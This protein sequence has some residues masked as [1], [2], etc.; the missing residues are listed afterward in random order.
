MTY[1][2]ATLPV[3]A[4]AYDEIAAKLR[5]ADYGHVFSGSGETEHIDMTHIALSRGED[6]TY[7]RFDATL[8]VDATMPIKPTRDTSHS[9]GGILRRVRAWLD[10]Y[11]DPGATEKFLL[12][13]GET[14]E[15]RIYRK[16][17]VPPG[18]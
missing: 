5:A 4:A 17:K 8:P 2:V 3:S 1:T 6:D 14:F 7:L 15:V 12:L 18:E 11:L 9:K 10:A 16:G 13:D